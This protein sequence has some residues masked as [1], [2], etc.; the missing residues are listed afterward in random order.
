MSRSLRNLSAPGNAPDLSAD[1]LGL[2]QTVRQRLLEADTALQLS[3]E[4]R[5][6]LK[7]LGYAGED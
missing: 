5:A 6:R 7:A 4:E 2:M 3:P 1:L